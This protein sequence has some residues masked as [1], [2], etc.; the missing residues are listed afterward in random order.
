MIG[1]SESALPAFYNLAQFHFHWGS[2]S[3]VGSEH[4]I[5]NHRYPMEVR[6]RGHKFTTDALYT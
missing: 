2:V 5:N 1:V 3:R 6:V 4:T